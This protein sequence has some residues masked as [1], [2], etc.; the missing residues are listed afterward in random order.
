MKIDVEKIE[1]AKIEPGDSLI[2]TLGEH[3]SQEQA[4]CLKMSIHLTYP[5]CKVM[6]LSKG[7][8]IEIVRGI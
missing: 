6:L 8:K 2:I 3:I 1:I 7:T 5:E 4:D